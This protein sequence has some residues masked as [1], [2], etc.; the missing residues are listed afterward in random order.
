[1]LTIMVSSLFQPGL[2]SIVLQRGGHEARGTS[3][4]EAPN[5]AGECIQGHNCIMLRFTCL[6]QLV[7]GASLNHHH[8][9]EE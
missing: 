9:Y 2:H 1:M 5:V 6:L 8:A 3:W 4:Q 7:D